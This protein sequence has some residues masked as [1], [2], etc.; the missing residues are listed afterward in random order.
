MRSGAARARSLTPENVAKMMCAPVRAII[1]WDADRCRDLDFPFPHQDR[2]P[3]VDGKSDDNH[4]MPQTRLVDHS[5]PS[6]EA[7]AFM[8]AE[9]APRRRKPQPG[10]LSIKTVTANKAFRACSS[11]RGGRPS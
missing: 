7:A 6:A 4:N 8:I 9:A 5:K 3:P 11:R 2:K 10:A 1:A